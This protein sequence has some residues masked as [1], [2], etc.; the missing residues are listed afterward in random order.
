MNKA[1]SE[2]LGNLFQEIGY[3]PTTVVDEANLIVLNSCIVRQSA[4]ERVI[5]KLMALRFLKRNHPSVTLA[6]TGCLVDDNSPRLKERFP[7]V[8]FFFKP[9]ENPQWI[10]NTESIVIPRKHQVSTFVPIIQGCNNFCSYCV[11]PYRRGREKSRPIV[12]VL[13][14]VRKL[15]LAGTKQVV[16]LGQ[17]VDS[18]GHDLPGKPSLTDL[19]LELS[20]IDDLE[21]IRFLTN[22][23]KDMGDRL[24]RT[25]TKLEK[26]CE[27]INLPVQSGNDNI[28]M[29]MKR[30]YT[31]EQ[32]RWL[33]NKIRKYIPKVAISTDVIVGFPSESEEQ[34]MATI[35]LLRE[36]KFD[37]VHIAAYSQRPGTFASSEYE[38]NVP[39]LEKKERLIILEQLQE[40]ISSEINKKLLGNIIEVLVEGS[41]KGKWHGRTRS[42][43]LVFFTNPENLL[44][45][46][47]MIRVI[48]TS[49]WSLQGEV[50]TGKNN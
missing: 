33:V 7:Y 20:K 2:R 17:N 11:V 15:V 24:I 6:L 29:A 8:D 12:E 21:R 32:Y 34:F 26:V 31:V 47:V 49:P 3:Q 5:N 22:H 30:N 36:I 1:E 14:E 9:G 16:L 25:I 28:L 43:K 39:T 13:G 4:E 46:L 37:K 10:D 44:G 45:Q 27:Q 18:Y 19:L 42:G 50:V 35:E 23:P 41:K 38:D 48:K 40:E